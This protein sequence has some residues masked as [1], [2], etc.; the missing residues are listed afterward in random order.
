MAI[1]SNEK[2][3]RTA[4]EC[5][6]NDELQDN[7]KYKNY[8]PD[9][10][11]ELAEE[12]AICEACETMLQ[13]GSLFEE[14]VRENPEQANKLLQA[15]R[16]VINSIKSFFKTH[17]KYARSEI[18]RYIVCGKRKNRTSWELIPRRL[19]KCALPYWFYN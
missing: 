2:A 12:E 19:R 11:K 13:D 4:I 16:K 1:A 17:G 10:M 8:S 3:L 5:K 6:E 14:L 15:I 9:E 7:K 18:S